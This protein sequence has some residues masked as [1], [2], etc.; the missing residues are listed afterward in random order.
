VP[1][2]SIWQNFWTITGAIVAILATLSFLAFQIMEILQPTSNPYVGIWTFLI[3]PGVLV[4]GLILIPLGYI[5]ERR[6]RR[7]LYPDVKD[8]PRLPHFD[9]NNPAH[10]RGLLVFGIGTLLVIPIV[11]MASYKGY[12]YTDSTQFCGQVCHS[13]MS[14]EYTAYQNSPHA[15]VTC[16]ACHIGPGA[17]W[18]VKAKISGVR[19]VLAVMLNTYSRPI[20]TPVKDLRPARETCEQCHW[21]AKFFASQLRSRVHFESDE[22]NTRSEVQVLLKTGGGDSLMGPP[23]GIHWHMALS[24]EIQYWASD[25][26]RQVIP[27]IRAKD[28]SGKVTIYRAN[29]AAASDPPENEIRT[30]D[31]MDCHNRPT[32]NILPPDRGVNISIETGRLDRTLPFIKK[33]AVAA[34]TLPYN[35]DAE[36][37]RG[38]EAH[39]REFYKK[40]APR[41][42]PSE[43]AI[44]QAVTEA[45]AL[46]HRSFFPAMRVSWRAYPDNIGHMMFD[47]CFRCHD[48]KHADAQ[49]RVISRDCSSCHQF[50]EAANPQA[51]QIFR[52][53]VPEHPLK[54][55][56][57][58]AQLKCSQCHTGGP[59]PERTCAG[60]HSEQSSFRQGKS[61]GLPGL[62]G[63]TP[64][65]MAGLECGQCHDLDKPQTS[66]DIAAQC[67]TCHE[68]GYGAMIQSWKDDAAAGRAKA[69]AAID[70][71][72]KSVLGAGPSDDQL[73]VL[74]AQMREALAK[75][76]KAGP[77]HNLDFRDAIYEQILNLAKTNVRQPG[78]K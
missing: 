20:P 60:C 78:G 62:K 70:E 45:R 39:I 77:Q 7:K 18:Y 1:M 63:A 51:P 47:G 44:T 43:S 72:E 8:W 30:L 41:G 64:S 4:F 66:A 9:P 34:L 3:L 50:L 42:G 56:G 25:S 24:Q 6:L 38:I 61:L 53:G 49:G 67:E 29:G 26:A 71:L 17:D 28:P 75:V 55:Q 54:L 33:V 74:I 5:H 73:K 27:W 2:K 76:D 15:R 19:Q 46:Y 40:L 65:F 23:S 21:P 59:A 16:A 31:C 69:S 32:H 14:P 68:K 13:V 12:H 58:H 36:A 35:N 22:K 48:G 37:D 11:G 52:Q 57:E 10:L